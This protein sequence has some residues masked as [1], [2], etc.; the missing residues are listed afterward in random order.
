VDS[1]EQERKYSL[2]SEADCFVLASSYEAF[3]IVLQ[4][5]MSVGLCIVASDVAGPRSILKTKEMLC[6][7]SLVILLSLLIR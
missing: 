4:E 3:G 7:L 2:L 6:F 1:S 5:A